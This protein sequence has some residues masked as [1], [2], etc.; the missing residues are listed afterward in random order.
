VCK[1]ALTYVFPIFSL[2]T[3]VHRE[4][5]GAIYPMESADDSV[6]EVVRIL[7]QHTNRITRGIDHSTAGHVQFHVN[8]FA[9]IGDGRG[10]ES[11]G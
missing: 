4:N 2:Q 1:R 9:V 6:H 11:S 10:Q 8:D 3:F 7:R 5:G